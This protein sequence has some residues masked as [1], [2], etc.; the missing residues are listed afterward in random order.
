MV[1]AID[2][3]KMEKLASGWLTELVLRDNFAIVP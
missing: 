3:Q 2:Y 1:V